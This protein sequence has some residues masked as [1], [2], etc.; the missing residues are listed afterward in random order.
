MVTM[1]A[2]AAEAAAGP[3][4]RVT[5][6]DPARTAAAWFRSH[7]AGPDRVLG[8]WD[9]PGGGAFVVVFERGPGG[10]R[11]VACVLRHAAG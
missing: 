6:G 10:A 8:F 1:R 9:P 2:A 3:A 11:W 7:P 5:H 4:F